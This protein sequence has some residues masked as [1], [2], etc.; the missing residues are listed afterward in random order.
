MDDFNSGLAHP[1]DAAA[2]AE[3]TEPDGQRVTNHVRTALDELAQRPDRDP[4]TGKFVRGTQAA[5]TDSLERNSAFWTA[6]SDAKRELVAAASADLAVD[7]QSAITHQGLIDAWAEARLLR[8]AMFARMAEQGGPVTGK[9]RARAMFKSYLAAL[10]R[11][12]KLAQTLGL[13]RQPKP[14]QSIDDFLVESERAKATE[15]V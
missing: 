14:V 9:G 4:S 11:E 13:R 8:A 3:Q 7:A 5:A 15:Q 10:D 12:V 6:V 2:P 1:P